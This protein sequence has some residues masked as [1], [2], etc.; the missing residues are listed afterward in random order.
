M[1]IE[2]NTRETAM[3]LIRVLVAGAFLM[4]ITPALHAAPADDIKIML[5][6]GKAVDAY[7]LGSK[8]PDLLGQPAFDFYFGI[9]AIDSGHAG[10]GVL[11]LERYM[12]NFPDNQNGRLELARGYFVLGENARAREEFERVLTLNPPAAVRAN[13]ERFLDAIRSRESLYTTTAGFFLEAGVGYDS[14]VSGGVNNSNINLPIYGNVAVSP[15]G[16]KAGTRFNWLA[17]G[18]QISRPIAP[19]VAVFAGAQADG[20]FN[21]TNSQFDQQNIAASGGLTYLQ[22]KNF[23]RVTASHSEVAVDDTRF[24]DINSIAGEWHHQLDELQTISPFVQYAQLRYTG[25]NIPRDADFYA[26][27]LGYRKTFIGDWQPLFTA[28]VNGGQEH[29]IRGRPDL[30]RDLYG[31]RIA[32]AVTPAPK[33]G[34]SVGGSYQNSR[35]QGPDALLLT[36]RRDDYYALDAVASYAYTRNLSVRAELLFSKNDSNLALYA[37]R[38]DTLALKLRYDFK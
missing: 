37:Y 10:E 31:D 15:S 5:E 19:G 28:S 35:Y 32:L 12:I 36:T 8:N 17:A 29:D 21:N 26:L 3:P 7:N 24:R 9:A 6:Q 1:K 2:H 38:R 16:V 18:G 13:I 30:G 11:A 25:N 27:G 14:N 4:S 23:Y 33:W 20:K 22:N 34:I